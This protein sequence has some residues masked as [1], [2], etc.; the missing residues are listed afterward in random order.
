MFS[1]FKKTRPLGSY[2]FLGT[3]F[4]SHLLPGI[5]DGAKDMADSLRLIR[6]LADM[7]FTRLITTPH[8]MADLYPNTPEAIL[9]KRD[10]VRKAM[11][12]A[13]IS[14]PLDAAAEYLMDEGFEALLETGNLLALPGNR[15]LVE[16]SFISEP[17][18]LDAYLF[19]LQTKGYRPVLAHPERYLFLR[20]RMSRYQE[21][22]ERGCEFQLNLLSLTGY[23]GKPTR[24]N[25]L[26]LLKAGLIDYAASDLH[27]DRHAERL[28]AAL[29]DPGIAKALGQATLRND[30]L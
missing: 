26:A 10:E 25:A 28:E 4:H 16:M 12:E 5:D 23:Y 18:K 20:E 30:T 1:F 27:H 17:P 6:R 2:R 19:R 22:R 11:Q 24:E 15:V 13:G 8:I 7:G 21:L 14:L 3:D 29:Q 9:A